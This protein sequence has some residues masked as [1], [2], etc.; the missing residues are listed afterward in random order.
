MPRKR[1]LAALALTAAA[2][3]QTSNTAPAIVPYG[4]SITAE[5]AKKLA[6][7]AIEEAKKNNWAMSVAVVDAGGFLVYFERMQDNQL[8]SPEIA[9]AKAKSAV[10]FRRPTKAFQDILAA[11]G[12]GL[13]VLKLDGAVPVAGGFPLIV[14]G[15][16]IGGIGA[17]GG[18]A[19]QDEKT[20]Q[21]GVAVAG[22]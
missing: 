8:A 20:A 17:S 11:G 2:F 5:A 21:A 10:L 22:K 12:D 18:S 1:T 16:I 14:D 7:A 6:A 3:G 4:T 9:I 19:D 13:R 15:K